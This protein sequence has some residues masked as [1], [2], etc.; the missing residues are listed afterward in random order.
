MISCTSHLKRSSRDQQVQRST[1]VFSCFDVGSMHTSQNKAHGTNLHTDLLDE[2][3][4]WKINR[5]D[6]QVV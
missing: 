1:G 6:L 2:H 4:K 3:S 5:F